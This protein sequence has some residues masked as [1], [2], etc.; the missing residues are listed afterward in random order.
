[1]TSY[2]L[3]KGSPM[4]NDWVTLIGGVDGPSSLVLTYTVTTNLTSGED[5]T[6]RYRAMNIVGQGPWSEI[7]TIKAAGVPF[8]PPTPVLVSSTDGTITIG[9]NHSVID[10]GGH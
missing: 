7:V 2:E 10:N 4:L 6:F 1:M 9:F 5:Y 3:Q 8:P